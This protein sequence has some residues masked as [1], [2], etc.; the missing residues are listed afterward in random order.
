LFAWNLG[1]GATIAVVTVSVPLA[2]APPNVPVMAAVDVAGTADVAT[3]NVA[4]KAPAATVTVAGV[5]AMGSLDDKL[6]TAPPVPAGPVR[7][8]VP[9]DG[10]PPT[11]EAGLSVTLRGTG[12]VMVRVSASET[13]PSFAVIVAVVAAV[14]IEVV[15]EKVAD[16]AL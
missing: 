11:T 12:V 2:D 7:V 6:T 3:V 4:L 1:Q 10:V 9:V 16:V 5:V 13:V 14:T 8:T 15:T